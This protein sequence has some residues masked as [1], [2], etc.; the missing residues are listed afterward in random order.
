[1]LKYILLGFLNYMPMT[2]YELEGYIDQSTGHFWHAKLSQI[3]TTLKSLEQDRLVRSHIEPQEGRPDRRVYT[4]TDAGRA[5]LQKWLAVPIVEAPQK[6]DALLVKVFFAVS[7][8]KTSLLTQ[9]RLQLDLHRQQLKAY[10]EETPRSIQGMVTEHP[11]LA[12]DALLWDATRRYGVMYEE[13]Y[14]RWLEETIDLIEQ[15]NRKS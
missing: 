5:D 14:I 7:I 12:E 2:G 9:L 3:Y 10:Q 6:K 11:E 4:I 13:T 1:M 8:D 15:Q